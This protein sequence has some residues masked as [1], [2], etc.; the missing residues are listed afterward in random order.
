MKKVL[1]VFDSRATFSYSNNVIKHFN[2]P[3]IK[4]Q[5]VVTGNYLD[6]KFGV[7]ISIFKKN[8]IK[9]SKKIKFKSPNK[10][11][12]SWPMHLGDAVKGFS[13]TLSELSPDLIVLTGDRVETLG[14]CIAASYMN[15]PIAHIQAGDKSGHIDDLARAAIAKFANIHFASCKDS[16]KR[17]QSWGEKKQSIFNVGAPQLD[18]IKIKKNKLNKNIILVIF[19]PVLNENENIN[20]QVKNL[21]EALNDNF[22]S[23]IIWIYPNNDYGH[24]KITNEIKKMKKIKIIKNLDRDKFLDLLTNTK[25]LIGNSSCGII[26][27][28]LLKIPVLN[29]GN[30]QNGRPQSINIVNSNYSKKAISNKIKFILNNKKFKNDLKKT[31]NIYFKFNSGKKIFKIIE[32]N[33]NIIN[34]FKKY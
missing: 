5:T 20:A 13:K 11:K 16:V 7:N 17:L 30:R 28:P 24:E 9:I 18:D 32:K 22:D 21:Y 8:K 25:I 26:E 27:A 6:S 19:H 33:I 15:I 14:F 29:I 3:K 34:K 1:F 31:K 10:A 4:I 12:F 2:N 23:N